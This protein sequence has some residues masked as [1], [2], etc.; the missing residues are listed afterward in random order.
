MVGH[1]CSKV[2]VVRSVSESLGVP[3]LCQLLATG[4]EMGAQAPPSAGP[5]AE[6]DVWICELEVRDTDRVESSSA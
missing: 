2:A 6:R 1:H 3:P 4:V 5:M